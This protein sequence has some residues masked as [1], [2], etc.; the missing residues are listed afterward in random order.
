MGWNMSLASY[1]RIE[2]LQQENL[3]R[4]I[5]EKKNNKKV[6]GFYCTYSP[7]ELAIAAG[8]IAVSLCSTKKEPLVA[9]DRDLPQ[10][11]CPFVRSLYDL[12]VTDKCPYFHL[13]DMVIGETTC[14]GKKKVYEL[15]CELKP[16]HVMN[17][18]QIPDSASSLALWEDEIRR[19]KKAIE[20][21]L[22]TTITDQALRQAI[23]LTNE[24]ARARKELFDLNKA[25]PAPISGTELLS[26]TSV[27]YSGDRQ[28]GISAL[29]GLT[30][31]IALQVKQG[32]NP[33]KP[34]SLRILVTGCP[35]SKQDD[36][37]ITLAEECGG[38]VVAMEN[39]GGY[40]T[41]DLRIDESDTRDPLTL[42]AEKYIRVPC[43]VMS[44][45]NGRIK[46]LEQM[47]TD[48]QID[49]VIDLTWQ[50]CH[51][52][53]IESY[54]VGKLVKNKMGRGFLHL[55]TNF[56]NSDSENLRVRIEAFIEMLRK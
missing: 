56:S 8:A 33:G 6:L 53:N 55:E 51:T 52:Y 37:V 19:L 48:F 29:D 23:H 41:V 22:D 20:K 50:A 1:A 43:S 24:D 42:L 32:H 11:L 35:I 31:E 47:I 12:A 28:E 3:P 5:Q 2:N 15:L 27:D 38:Q 46:L 7:I 10:N 30:A 14:D 34:D 36:K 16:F 54:L 44:P 13:S 26:I 40:K 39:C 18:P 4:I 21:Q 17:L 25:R 45:N 49:G 9:A